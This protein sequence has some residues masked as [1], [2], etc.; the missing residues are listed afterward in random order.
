M[1]SRLGIVSLIGLFLIAGGTLTLKYLEET[2]LSGIIGPPE[3]YQAPEGRVERLKIE[4]SVSKYYDESI[5]LFA[6]GPGSG[7]LKLKTRD[8]Q[9]PTLSF[10][11]VSKN[12]VK[13]FNTFS[14]CLGLPIRVNFSNNLLRLFSTEVDG[15]PIQMAD[16]TAKKIGAN[17]G[18]NSIMN[19]GLNHEKEDTRLVMRKDRNGKVVLVRADTP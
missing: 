15:D 8:G 16:I 2:H 9:S 6:F 5:D 4:G 11:H 10:N 1:K 14:E 7:W 13:K 18:A 12:D 3:G 17:S 19:K